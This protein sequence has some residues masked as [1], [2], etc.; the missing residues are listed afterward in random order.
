[1]RKKLYLEKLIE[2]FDKVTNGETVWRV[3]K[4]PQLSLILSR[5]LSKIENLP[6]PEKHLEFHNTVVL[7]DVVKC[8]VEGTIAVS[9]IG[10]RFGT[11]LDRTNVDVPC[12]HLTLHLT[13]DL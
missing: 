7:N 10:E 5:T 2:I 12:K 1:M 13:F 9:I 6:S 11:H 8:L 3:D 4:L